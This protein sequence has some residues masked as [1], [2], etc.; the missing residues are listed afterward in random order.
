MYIIIPN[1]FCDF[2]VL[3]IILFK[4]KIGD[5][6][7]NRGWQNISKYKK[8]ITRYTII[9]ALVAEVISLPIFKPGILFPYGLAIGVCI[10][11]VNLHVISITIEQAVNR[12][13]KGPVILGLV[14]RILLYGGAFLLAAKTSG[15][16]AIGAAIGFLLPRIVLYIKYGLA[17]AIRRKLGKEP[18]AIY[19][20]DTRS[21]VF[22]KEP[23][24][25]KY[26]RGRTYMTHRHFK[27]RRENG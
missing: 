20:T 22:I 24:M 7:K 8:E 3:T 23:L 19:K 10:A 26:K 18:P 11:I 2:G 21:M 15:V 17:P 13:K 14:I 5:K 1:G 9:A 6:S 4:H 16:T 25:V 12:G 27:K